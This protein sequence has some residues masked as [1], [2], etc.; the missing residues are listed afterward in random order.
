MPAY[1]M[2]LVLDKNV[3]LNNGYD[4]DKMEESLMNRF[5]K[6]GIK[7]DADDFYVGESF[8][9]FWAII[10]NLSEEDWFMDS[11]TEWKWYNG[12]YRVYNDGEYPEEDLLTSYQ[13]ERKV[14]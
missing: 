3:L 11:V 6:L 10:L 13:S 8:E 12:D 2:K 1:K 9:A 14:G 7:K 4:A 5:D